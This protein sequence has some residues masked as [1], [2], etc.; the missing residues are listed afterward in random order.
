MDIWR[1]TKLKITK[2]SRRQIQI[3]IITTGLLLFLITIVYSV[4]TDIKAVARQMDETLKYVKE[5]CYIYNRYNEASQTKGLMRAI[6]NAQQVNRNLTYTK[7]EVTK[8]KLKTY[9]EEQKLTGIIILDVNG[10]VKCEYST[11]NLNSRALQNEIQKKTVLDVVAY[12]RKTYAASIVLEDGSQV[13]L[14]AYGR[15]DEKGIII[16][17]YHTTAEY[18]RNYNLTIQSLFSGYDTY[19]SG[20]I[21]VTDGKNV[22]ASNDE[23]LI[24]LSSEGI[25]IIQQVKQKPANKL[26]RV[27]D[28]KCRYIGRMTKGRDYYVYMFIDEQM[29]FASVF[30]NLLVVLL[31]YIFVVAS[32]FAFRRRSNA[33]LLKIQMMQEEAY[34]QKLLQEAQRADMANNAKTEFLQRMSHDI[35]TPINGIRGMIEVADYYKDDLKKQDECRRKIWD[36]SGYLLELI[37]EVLDMPLS[38]KDGIKENGIDGKKGEVEFRNVSFCYPDAEKD[39]IE[40]ISFTAHKGETIAFIGSTGCGKS[41]VINMIPRFYD[42]TK[43]EVLVDGV[44]VKEYTQKA[45]RNKIGYVSQKAVLFTGSIKSNVAYGDNGTKGFT[46]DVVKQAIETAQAKEFVDKTDGGVDAFVAQGGSNFS[47][48]QKQRLSIARAICRHPEILIFDDSFSA[49]DYKT[50]RVLRDTL[51]KTCADATRFIVAQRIGTIR[52]ADKIIVL[53]DGKIAGMGKHNELM[54]TC[55]VYR[56]IAYSQLSKEELA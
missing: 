15:S 55:E 5:Q 17:F 48:G 29:A 41:T 3:I 14:A 20:M 44:N 39:V 7:D 8:D 45:L 26:V 52:D 54:E 43:G 30:K 56:Q 35:R 13:D 53:D 42:A 25:N 32:V 24:G 9:A 12:P 2:L 36:A 38:I 21:V 28:R 46:D 11:D 23:N 1:W 50:D 27:S 10:K 19:S 49:L 6:E 4:K 18:A 16:T 51:R 31:L 22:V 33:Q 34:K 40:D 37:N 47:G